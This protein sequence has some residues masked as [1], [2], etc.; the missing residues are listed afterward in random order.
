MI[1]NY[2][3]YAYARRLPSDPVVEALKEA[4]NGFIIFKHLFFDGSIQP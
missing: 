2:T 1:S 4:Q 3:V